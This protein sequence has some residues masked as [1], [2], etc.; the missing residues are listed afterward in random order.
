LSWHLSE[1]QKAKLRSAWHAKENQK[2]LIELKEFLRM[3]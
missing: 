2:V 3:K 1:K